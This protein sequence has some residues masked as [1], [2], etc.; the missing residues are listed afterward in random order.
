MEVVRLSTVLTSFMRCDGFWATIALLAA[1]LCISVQIAFRPWWVVQGLARLTFDS[2][3]NV[4]SILVTENWCSM[5]GDDGGNGVDVGL[6]DG[7]EAQGEG[8]EV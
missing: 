5:G 8:M 7:P 2:R 4:V 6:A 3:S 1:S